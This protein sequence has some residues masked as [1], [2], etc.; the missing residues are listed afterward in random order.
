MTARDPSL[1]D[2]ACRDVV[3]L[4]TAYLDGALPPRI[5]AGIDAHLDGCAGC[6]NALAQWR[7][8]IALAGRL[9]AADVRNTDDVTRDRIL[10]TLRLL[11]RR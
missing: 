1:A 9:T 10:S 7:T 2:V 3:D 8:V 5:R 11:R 6:R 4:L